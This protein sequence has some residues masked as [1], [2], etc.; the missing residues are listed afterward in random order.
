MS[1]REHLKLKQDT[2]PLKNLADN[3]WQYIVTDAN[4][5]HIGKRPR[6]SWL[7]NFDKFQKYIQKHK[8]YPLT[9]DD[10]HI[11]KWISM[12]RTK[13]RFNRLGWLE[14]EILNAHG[15]IWQNAVDQKWDAK[16]EALKTYLE[17]HDKYPSHSDNYSLYSWV[18]AQI[19]RKNSLSTYR[20]KR[21]EEI[22]FVWDIKKHWL[23][24][25]WSKQ[26]E[27]LTQFVTAHDRY[28]FEAD[29]KRLAYWIRAQ[30]VKRNRGQLTKEQIKKLDN[31][32][33]E[34]RAYIYQN[35]EK[36]W[37]DKYN[38]LRA[39]LKTYGGHPTKTTNGNLAQ[40]V[41]KQRKKKRM[42]ALSDDKLEMFNAIGFDWGDVSTYQKK[43]DERLGD[44]AA[45]LNAHKKYPLFSE[46]KELATWVGNHR[47]LKES[48]RLSEKK[49]VKLNAIGF[50]WKGNIKDEQWEANYLKLKAYLEGDRQRSI[51]KFDKPLSKWAHFQKVQKR[52]GKLSKYR[53]EKLNSIG[54]DWGQN[55][56][57]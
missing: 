4:I 25:L 21:L 34:W 3:I 10:K 37:L 42:G 15:F 46:H 13:Y 14:A 19:K 24:G 57:G 22:D 17:T 44:L 48:G 35:F 36:Q 7:L 32:N 6:E 38:E 8:R 31:I 51:S 30:R 56:W 27:E 20:R 11:S 40:W 52:E 53:T 47:H 2:K 33:F 5:K 23:D 1:K 28:P 41:Y 45:Y 9:K 12:Q 49:V 26:Y 54:F 55:G 50:K 16:Y 18:V 39:H 29:N 43:W